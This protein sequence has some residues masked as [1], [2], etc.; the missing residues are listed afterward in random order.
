MGYKF[1]PFTGTLDVV[2]STSSVTVTEN[3][4]YKKIVASKTVTIPE[5]QQ[6]IV[7]K[8]MVIE[9]ELIILGESVI[10]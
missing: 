5:N 2:N 10:I 1:N 3:F 7:K 4:S 6:M 8:S 9:G